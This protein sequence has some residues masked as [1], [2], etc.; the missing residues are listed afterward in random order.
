MNSKNP[1]K[2]TLTS[3]KIL[4]QTKHQLLWDLFTAIARMSCNMH[5]DSGCAS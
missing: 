2:F 3:D 5:P 1:D 4:L